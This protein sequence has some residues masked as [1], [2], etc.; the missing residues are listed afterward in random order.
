MQSRCG[1]R[2]FR[3]I[4][5][6]TGSRGFSCLILWLGAST[7]GVAQQDGDALDIDYA[8]TQPLAAESL[9]LDITRTP[10]GRFVA[11]GERGHIVLSDDGETWVQARVVPTR[12]TL[13]SV[14]AADR[15]LFAAGHDTVILTSGD[16]GETW[17]REYYDPERQ[18]A[19]MDLSFDDSRNGVAMGAYGLYMVTDDGGENWYDESVDYENE[20]HLNR[21]VKLDDERRMIAGEAGYSYRSFDGGQ[22]WEAMDLPYLGSMWGAVR[23]AA[24]CVL[25][26][27]LRGH[28]LE[29]CDF[30]D[31]WAELKADT[32]SSLSDAAWSDGTTVIVG[33]SGVVLVREGDGRFKTHV[34]SRGVDF[35]GVLALGDG[36]Y[37]LVGEEGVYSFPEQGQG[38]QAGAPGASDG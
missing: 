3:R 8:E 20:Y 7:C 30:G 10:A 14:E 37:L 15:R 18:Q 29:S 31:S 13:T 36:R 16:G 25:F 9:L 38:R 1:A 4:L 12:S 27:G 6:Q 26:Y 23:T 11:V 5:G 21:M 28:I 35:A 19:V 17:T 22:S 2:D 33:N 32:I 34:H 24:D